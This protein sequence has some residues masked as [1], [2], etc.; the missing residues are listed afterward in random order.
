M[1]LFETLLLAF[2]GGPLGILRGYIMIAWT[3]KQVLILVFLVK[4]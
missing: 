4:A 2:C 1:I 3:R